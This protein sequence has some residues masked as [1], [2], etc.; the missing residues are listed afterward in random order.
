MKSLIQLNCTVFQGVVV[1]FLEILPSASTLRGCPV[2]P[3]LLSFLFYQLNTNPED[4]LD[5]EVLSLCCCLILSLF[6][7]RSHSSVLYITE[8]QCLGAWS[9]LLSTVSIL[10]QDPL[11]RELLYGYTKCSQKEL[12]LFPGGPYVSVSGLCQC[13]YCCHTCATVARTSFAEAGF[14]L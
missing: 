9:Q 8:C 4:S 2:M 5:A 10:L 14:F 12:Q 13:E 3:G 7:C 6:Q 1:A 11:L